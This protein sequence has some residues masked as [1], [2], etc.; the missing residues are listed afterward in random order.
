[1][2]DPLGAET[3]RRKDGNPIFQLAL[4]SNTQDRSGWNEAKLV[5]QLK[6]GADEAYRELMRRYQHKVAGIAFGISMD[7]EESLDIAQE[8][9]LQVH[10]NIH[11]FKGDA[12][13]STWLH[14]IT[15]NQALNW[16]RKWKRRFRWH[17]QPAQREDGSEGAEMGSDDYNPENQYREKELQRLFQAKLKALP[18]DIRAVFI[19]KEV[20]GLSYEEIAETL[21]IRR[22]TVSSR[23]FYAR[24][25]LKKAILHPEETAS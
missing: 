7:R 6:L 3:S 5:A 13:L 17:H 20:E 12:K 4:V 9:F 18:E 16:R 15:V 19:L 24:K 8:V 25:R 22:G 1:M 10:R 2:G 14:R 23:L 11:G 21:G